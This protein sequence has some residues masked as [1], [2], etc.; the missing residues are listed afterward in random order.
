MISIKFHD[1]LI[2][3]RKIINNIK[4]VYK[5]SIVHNYD[6]LEWYYEANLICKSSAVSYGIN[7][8][9]VVGLTAALS[10]LSNWNRNL[11]LLIMVL[12][13]NY[14]NG[15][16]LELPYLKLGLRKCALILELKDDDNKL[17]EKIK[18]ILSGEKIKSFFDNISN[19]EKSN[20]ITLDRHA[21]S[22]ALGIKLD[23]K[24]FKNNKMTRAQY[25]FFSDC[26]KKCANEL[27]INPLA[28]QAQTWV[29]WR[30]KGQIFQK[31]LN[32][33]LNIK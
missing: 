9:K 23:K 10:P 24:D 30:E 26:Y 12:N 15:N 6:G 17:I 27:G 28:L 25:N 29:F 32:N 33:I 7:F 3:Q 13:C 21:L 20:S 11:E 19:P 1:E 18:S 8:Y 14:N 16:L 5:E 2:S 31:N 4:K 22:I